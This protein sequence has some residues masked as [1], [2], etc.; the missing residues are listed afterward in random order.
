MPMSRAQNC[1]TFRSVVSSRK[2]CRIHKKEKSL[3][4][5]MLMKAE[6]E[7]YATLP[8]LKHLTVNKIE[9]GLTC[10]VS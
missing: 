9:S 1:L 10:I 8:L 5:L 3:I 4:I 7:I 2:S 6:V